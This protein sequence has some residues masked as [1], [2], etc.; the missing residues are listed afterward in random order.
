[1]EIEFIKKGETK[2]IEK[3]KKKRKKTTFQVG[4]HPTPTRR[5]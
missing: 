3:L 2:R 4:G 1:M 5:K